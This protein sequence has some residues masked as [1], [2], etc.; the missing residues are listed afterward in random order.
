MPIPLSDRTKRLTEILLEEPER[1]RISQRLAN[2]AAEDTPMW[3]DFSPEGMER[4]HFS[5]LKLIAQHPNNENIA[6][7]H[8]RYDWRDLF[9][10]AGF[11]EDINE[12]D[13]WCSEILRNEG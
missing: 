3:H 11:G 12:H 10:A 9:M 2:E 5:I 1:T 6:F 13:N 8:A 4:I 7:N